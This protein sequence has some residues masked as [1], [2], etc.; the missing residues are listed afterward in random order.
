MEEVPSEV[1]VYTEEQLT[2]D[3]GAAHEPRAG[4]AVCPDRP[5]L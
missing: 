5:A 2:F 1:M 4:A 3:V